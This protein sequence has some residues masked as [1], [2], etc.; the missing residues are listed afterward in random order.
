MLAELQTQKPYEL[1][2]SVAHGAEYVAPDA[3]FEW[4]WEASDEAETVAVGSSFVVTPPSRYTDTWNE[5]ILTAHARIMTT[6][7]FY[8]YATHK[9][10]ALENNQSHVGY[11]V[12]P[13]GIVWP[14][15]QDYTF[16]MGAHWLHGPSVTV[17][18]GDP[19]IAKMVCGYTD[20]V[21]TCYLND[22]VQGCEHGAWHQRLD[23]GSYTL[24]VEI[25]DEEGTQL[26]E[27][28]IRNFAVT[29][30][31]A[32][33]A[34]AESSSD[35]SSYY[36]PA[37]ALDGDDETFWWTGDM[38]VLGSATFTVTLAQ[39]KE[40][41]SVTITTGERW[42]QSFDLQVSAD[43]VTYETL[44]QYETLAYDTLRIG[45]DSI[46]A[47][48]VRFEDITAEP[49]EWNTIAGINE[50]GIYESQ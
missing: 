47:K 28:L 24:R 39:E 43:G 19:A 50:I 6:G 41:N 7:G 44:G 9:I 48:Y 31:L 30:N 38:A 1:K 22:E 45:F 26:Q 29:P 8:V 2:V 5:T 13:Q 23:T 33:T 35:W 20:C 25:H 3:V 15:E 37:K 10:K 36:S 17:L 49:D 11:Q 12:L 16:P 27:A 42:L 14:V 46:N 18:P 4:T 40:I 21:M 34:T 32:A